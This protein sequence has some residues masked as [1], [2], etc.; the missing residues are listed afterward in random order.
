MLYE[1][2]S[3]PTRDKSILDYR[4]DAISFFLQDSVKDIIHELCS[5]LRH[6]KN[7]HRILAKVKECKATSNDWQ[8][9][10]KVFKLHLRTTKLQTNLTIF[11]LR[12]SLRTILRVYLPY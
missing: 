12:F 7:F 8:N 5:S 11:P 10:L 6:I 3:K 9:I 4:H 2:V 1:W